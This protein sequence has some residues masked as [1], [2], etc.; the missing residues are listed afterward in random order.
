MSSHAPRAIRVV[1]ECLT[2]AWSLALRPEDT[3]MPAAPLCRRN[4]AKI[5]EAL[6][7][8]AIRIPEWTPLL[9]LPV[10]YALMHPSNG[11][12]SASSR[13]WPQHIL[14]AEE[15]FRSDVT[16]REHIIHELAH[17]WL[18]LIQE[19][20]AFQTRGGQNLTLPSG[21]GTRSVAE[22]IGAAH[23]AAALITMYAAIGGAPT[24]RRDH[25][26][27]YGSGCL[28]VLQEAEGDLTDAGRQ[29]VRRLKEAF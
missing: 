19:I 8:L 29:V 21:T 11:A 28:T 6:N 10:R 23:V 9:T 22:V 1:E 24:D 13:A 14:L 17:Q 5:S 27:W 20:W 4:K 16:L 2:P 26:T 7:Q 12:I 18:Y 15:A 3:P 25:L